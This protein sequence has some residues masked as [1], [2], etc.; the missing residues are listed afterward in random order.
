MKPSARPTGKKKTSEKLVSCAITQA[1][2]T[3]RTPAVSPLPR[4]LKDFRNYH[5]G[6]TILVCGC[7][8]S[9]NDVVAPERFI[10]IGVND[11]GRLFQPDYLVVLNPR[12]QFKP[13]R[14][15]FV[16]QSQ[17][18]AIFTQL[19]L[20]ILHPHI[21]RFRLGRFGG[22]DFSDPTCLPHT[23]NSPYVALCLAIHM[24]AKK[25]GL[26]GVD[27]TNDHFFA[28]TGEHPLNRQFTQIDQEYKRLYEA[29][30]RLGIEVVN[31][32]SSS[33]LTALPKISPTEFASARNAP[34]PLNIVS[35]STTPVAG[36]PAILSRCIAGRSGHGCR[37][38][39]PTNGYANGVV[40]DRDVEWRSA[41]SEADELLRSADLLIVH[42]G[43]VAESH[44]PLLRNK[45]VITMAHNYMWNVDA[46]FVQQ[47]WPG[48]VVG[49]YQATLPEFKRW[50]VVP[51]PMP[52]WESAFQPGP[53]HPQLTICYTPSGKHEVYSADHRLYWHSKGYDTTMRVLER[54]GRRFS[55]RLEVI[56]TQQVSHAESLAMKRRAHIV[57][58]E[59]VTGSYHR[60]SLEGLALGCVVV[61]GMGRLPSIVEVFAECTGRAAEIPF[62]CAGL[63]NLECVLTTL[64]EQGTEAL[65]A[66]GMRNRAWMERHWDFSQQWQ[67]FWEP[68]VS[69]AFEKPRMRD[70]LPA[71]PETFPKTAS[72]ETNPIP[73]ASGQ[74]VSVVVCH[75]GEERLPQLCATL[76]NLRRCSGVNETI[77]CDMGRHP[78]A[79]VSARK[80]ADKYIFIR[81]E[82]AF[83]R[84]RCLNIGTSLAEY[85]LVLWIDNDLIVPLDFV[86]NA[87]SEMRSRQLDYLIPYAAVN[88][89]SREDS[90][91]V[92][93]GIA[94]PADCKPVK[95]YKALYVCGG[96]GLVRRSFV[97]ANGGLSEMF[98]GWG[99]EDGAWWHKAKLLGRAE[100]I[101]QHNQC[102]YH[103]FHLD[104]GANGG[105]QHRDRN[106]H[107]A[108]N[109]AALTRMRSIRDRHTYLKRFPPQPLFS[110]AWKG[111]RV[112]LVSDEAGESNPWP[113]HQVGGALA[114]I[115]DIEVEHRTIDDACESMNPSHLDALVVLGKS[116][117]T[118]AWAK[119]PCE[120][121]KK[122]I[123]VHTESPLEEAAL[124]QLGEAGGIL[125]REGPDL[126]RLQS[127]GLQF[128]PVPMPASNLDPSRA[129]AL[130][131]LQP[132]SIVMGGAMPGIV[133]EAFSTTEAENCTSTQAPR[134]RS[135]MRD[136]TIL[137]TSFL[138]PG[139]LKDCLAGIEKNL[140]D[141]EVI[142][143]DDS[144]DQPPGNE[145]DRRFI[146]LPFDSG[147]SAK[148]NAGVKACNT[149]YLL[150]G[151]DDLDFSTV[152][153]REGIEKLLRVLD[154]HPMV[155]VAGGH[156]NNQQYEGFL[157]M[158]PGSYIKESRLFSANN[159]RETRQLLS[160]EY[161]V[162][163]VDL[164]VNYFLARTQSI[165]QFPWDE[166][167][168]IGGEHGDWFLTLKNAGKNVV[169]VSG[170]NINELPRDPT[171]EHAD[172]AT[173]RG[174]A[175]SLGHR[176]FLEKRG[177][178]YYFDFDTPVPATLRSAKT[179]VAV[180]TC[181]QYV[182]RVQAQQETWIP[183]ARAAGYEVEIFDGE[184][185]GVPDDYYS[186]IP[187]TQA[188][189]NWA[190]THGYDRILKVDDDCCI[191]VDR[192]KPSNFDYAGIVIA[193]NDCGST[194]PPGVPARPRG[195]YPYKYASGGAYWL[196][197]KAMEIIANAK[198]NGDWAEDRFVGNI[199]AK[200]GIFVRRIPDYAA[201]AADSSLPSG[202][203]LITQLPAPQIR[204]VFRS[205][206]N[207]LIGGLRSTQ[208]LSQPDYAGVSESS[209]Q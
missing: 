149:K 163:K 40:F 146:H 182:D 194:V 24:G 168:K 60:N 22:V 85:D 138:R 77:V 88:Y 131:I 96:A 185:L 117:I 61:N 153:V 161:E 63:E 58:D 196:S 137:I 98:R 43:K 81:N 195:T 136:I 186:L 105:S 23:R 35:Y 76:A 179:L 151:S 68:V 31:L 110:A 143:A 171:K 152:E 37:A 67:R 52:L 111:M 184:R 121:W 50:S 209:G 73:A 79:Q 53:K 124:Q 159:P 55:I 148:R 33:R 178:R 34:G 75:G 47:G 204:E 54:L 197:R 10:T 200:H 6:E 27:F 125:C 208:T 113:S 128:W 57:I 16:E 135:S 97:S 39:W 21:V 118:S 69:A 32:S 181:K 198:P 106:P 123:V 107:Y 48:V 115:T 139:Y 92:I 102:L 36:V 94:P 91:R 134:P 83:E 42:N 112:V 155:D 3:F 129:L 156:H 87:A 108:E 18:K 66:Q 84:A 104:C 150:M 157:E 62:V 167:M 49:Q 174:R 5:A 199:L 141:C 41:P 30:R 65:L 169:W 180:V 189:C 173:Y 130:R 191:R 176:I 1:A 26:T 80:W 9:L 192:L 114:D 160:Q 122:T 183:S 25:I 8:S 45:P 51:N 120:L 78:W 142:V 170:V 166:R 126:Q 145:T 177:I 71:H 19:D 193:A 164:I 103:L 165:R 64:I 70:R 46:S 2:P 190:L 28:A 127:A 207:R 29:C 4:E 44:R 187:K 95:I 7:G 205:A 72:K 13:D 89:L 175:L 93:D 109:L 154:E 17:A 203:T 59:C 38:V 11:V 188:I 116:A 206:N 144:G 132:L 86:S 172:Y 14:F 20:G 101:R 99:G 74:G 201:F 202:W 147:L 140:P 119:L 100:V 12:Q 90:R 15:R 133:T 56:R 158:S 82:G 162:Y